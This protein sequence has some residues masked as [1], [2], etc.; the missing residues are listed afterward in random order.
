MEKE[1]I[2][3]SIENIGGAETDRKRDTR[4]MNATS[5]DCRGS[6]LSRAGVKRPP[7]RHCNK[8]RGKYTRNKQNKHNLKKSLNRRKAL[9]ERTNGQ[10]SRLRSRELKKR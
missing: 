10:N 2:I 5:R 8:H 9:Q 7:L 1:T 6:S 4:A 3:A